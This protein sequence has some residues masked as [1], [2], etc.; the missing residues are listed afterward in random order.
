MD[1]QR[2]RYF[3]RVADEGSLTRAA[4]VLGIAQPALSRQ[5]HLLEESLGVTLFR[6]LPRG[7]QLTEEGKQLRSTLAEPLRQLEQAMQR[8]SSPLA[9]IESGVVLGMPDTAACVAA[10]PLLRRL[11]SAFP[12]V[13]FRL[14]VRDSVELVED[15]LTGKVD[16]AVIHGPAPDERLFATDLVVEDV[17]LVGG[18]ESDLCVKRPVRFS[19]LANY[20][21]VLP[22]LEPGLR[23]FV[24]K[25]ALRLS[26][27]IEI[28]YEIDSLAVSKELIEAG[29]AY[30]FLPI[31]AFAKEFAAGRLRY[32]PITEPALSHHLV[33]A[34]RP[35][36]VLPR[37]FVAHFGMLLR[38]EV[39]ALVASGTWPARVNVPTTDIGLLH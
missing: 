31:S 7:M 13:S 1:T 23:S 10:V 28:A 34:A 17:V 14:T 37:S 8:V 21:L 4:A 6:R 15:M 29:L 19:D 38:N 20:P 11:A 9:Q 18:P 33:F 2:L 39:A 12:N 36:L 22:G 3:L 30:G 32:A 35:K 26:I 27:S 24:E 5:V 25:T 16:L